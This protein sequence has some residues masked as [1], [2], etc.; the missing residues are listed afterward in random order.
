MTKPDVILMDLFHRARN[1]ID[2]NFIT[3]LN[4]TENLLLVC[5]NLQ[6]RAGIRLLLACLL[7]KV[8]NPTVDIRKPYTEIP[9]ADTFSGR[10]YDEQ[11]I[12]RIIAEE[13]L[14][15]NSTTAF[16][17]P[18]LRNIDSP[19][20]KDKALVGRPPALY[21]AILQLLDDV[22]LAKV[23]AEDLLLESLR[24]LIIYRDEKQQRMES[25]LG[26]LKTTTESIPLSAEAIVGLLE[27]HLKCRGASRLPVLIVAAA[28]QCATEYLRENIVSLYAHNAADEQTGALGDLEITLA[29]T[30]KIVTCY[31]MKLKKVTIG[32]VERAI[33]K[34]S[35][36]ESRI[37]NYIFITTEIIED[38]VKAF[39]EGMYE[40]TGGVEIVIL[41]CI[42]FI[43]HFLHLF[44]RLRTHFL[45]AYQSLVISEP[46]SAV[47]QPLKEVLLVLRQAAETGIAS[48]FSSTE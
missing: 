24:L 38:S 34:M 9:G 23:S 39:A 44:H 15:C 42:A 16:L 30:E 31:E 1:S 2:T 4:T 41:D 20:T 6:N 26:S 40:K 21:T 18:A 8:C 27:Q 33:T 28:Y 13:N 25:L 47:S 19:L 11:Y 5:R 46:E 29:S 12:A 10:F 48:S 43:R 45:D 37:D 22:Y 7:A 32:D 3:E 36:L 35:K 17:T 14:P